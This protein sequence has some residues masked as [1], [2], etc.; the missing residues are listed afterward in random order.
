VLE[1][2]TG[3]AAACRCPF[4]VYLMKIGDIERVQCAT[5]SRSEAEVFL[6]R[7]ANHTGVSSGE[8]INSPGPK[9]ANKISV[10]RVFINIQPELTHSRFIEARK[11]SSAAAS[12]TAMSL[13]ISS[14]LAW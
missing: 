5:L 9:T 4:R 14:R 3:M 8:H 11:I 1:N 2:N 6:I 10:H 13:S 12:S 7:S